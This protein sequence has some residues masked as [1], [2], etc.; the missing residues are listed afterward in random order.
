MKT[1]INGEAA[2]WT[3]AIWSAWA[4]GVGVEGAERANWYTAR[5]Y[6]DEYNRGSDKE[7]FVFSAHAP[8]GDVKVY[9]TERSVAKPRAPYINPKG[10]WR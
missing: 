4:A 2:A 7:G 5:P 8:N 9:V 10:D 1:T 6:V 3:P